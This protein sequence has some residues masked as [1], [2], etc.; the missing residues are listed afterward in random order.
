MLAQVR[1]LAASGIRTRR[2]LLFLATMGEEGHSDLHGARHFFRSALGRSARVFI[3][4][5][6]A[7]PGTIV[8]RGV[9]S[10]RYAVEFRGAGGHLWA[11]FSRYNP[12][13]A[14]SAASERPAR[15]RPLSPPRTTYN[16]GVVAAE[17]SVNAIPAVSLQADLRSESEAALAQLDEAF[18]EAVRH[19]H[20]REVSH[21]PEGAQSLRCE[22]IGERPTGASAADAPL[23]RSACVAL[24]AEGLHPQRTGAST[25]ANGR[26]GAGFRGELGR[27]LRQPAQHT[28]V[29]CTA[30]SGAV[31]AAVDLRHC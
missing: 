13:F 5:D 18:Q 3:T 2:S 28:G 9:G 21:R 23:V 12:V 24:S 14:L 19:G 4:I 27:A 7:E 6:H 30:G 25:D 10:R 31:A 17:G 26:G 20:E 1:A 15:L 16:L 22:R 29:V 11:H 8:H